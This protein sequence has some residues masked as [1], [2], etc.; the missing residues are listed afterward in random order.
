MWSTRR[1]TTG[2]PAF[3]QRWLKDILRGQ[4]GFTGAI[5]SDDLSMEGARHLD[6]GQ[7]GYAEAAALALDAGCDM[8]LLCNQSV[9]GGEAVDELLGRPAAAGRCRPLAARRG[10]RAAPPGAAAADAAADLGRADAPR[11]LPARARAPALGSMVAAPGACQ[12]PGGAGTGLGRGEAHLRARATLR[13]PMKNKVAPLRQTRSK[14]LRAGAPVTIEMV[15]QA[16]GVSP[17]TVSRILNGTAAVS[18]AKTPGRRRR[19]PAAG[20]RAQPG[21]ARTGR[22]A[23]VERGRRHAGDRQP[24]LRR[25]RCAASR[26]SSTRPATA[27]C[28]SAATGTPPRRRAAST[29]C[30][31][32]GSTASSCSPAA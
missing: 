16:A 30:A 8:V 2:R 14:T 5:F 9:D 27:R 10:Q 28:S 25:R 12:A 32:A 1:S 21:G 24:V 22:R 3:R 4:L 7:L 26:T 31:R 13:A 20:L 18:D 15:A 23:H 19:H 11:C 6:G 29:C 17:S